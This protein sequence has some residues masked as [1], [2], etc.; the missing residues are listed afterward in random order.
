MELKNTDDLRYLLRNSIH[1][2]YTNVSAVTKKAGIPQATLQKFMKQDVGMSTSTLFPVLE[3]LGKKLVVCDVGKE[4]SIEEIVKKESKV[5]IVQLKTSITK[6]SLSTELRNRIEE[7]KSAPEP[8]EKFSV[9][10]II[11]F[12]EES[13]DKLATI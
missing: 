5:P 11:E 1:E 3:V 7:Y 9:D 12:L 13:Y 8:K 4:N 10:L 2:Q 6:E